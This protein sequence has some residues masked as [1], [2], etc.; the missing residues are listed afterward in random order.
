MVKKKDYTNITYV[1]SLIGGIL[2]ILVGVF[3]IG[4]TVFFLYSD[5]IFHIQNQDISY[6]AAYIG[7]HYSLF[8]YY[9][10]IMISGVLGIVGARFL[11]KDTKKGKILILGGGISGIVFL[12]LAGFESFYWF[13]GIPFG[14]LIISSF[15][16]NTKK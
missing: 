2:G 13:L 9:S 11:K 12:I 8:I 15:L 5:Y 6:G 14:L 3:F 1:L 4:F 7:F 16:I 10:L